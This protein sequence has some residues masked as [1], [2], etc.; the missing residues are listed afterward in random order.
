MIFKFPSNT[1]S[2]LL[3]FALQSHKPCSLLLLS[4]NKTDPLCTEKT[5][6][7]FH[8]RWLGVSVCRQVKEGAAC[9]PWAHLCPLGK[10]SPRQARQE[11][12]KYFTLHTC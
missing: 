5:I 9:A 2:V 11:K 6:K 3:F 7:I 8:F 10:F 1:R 4:G 12:G